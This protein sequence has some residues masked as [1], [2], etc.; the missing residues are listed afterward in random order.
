MSDWQLHCTTNVM[1]LTLQSSTFLFYVHF[2][3]LY[4]KHIFY[5]LSMC[6]KFNFILLSGWAH[7][8][9]SKNLTVFKHFCEKVGKGLIHDVTMQSNQ[10]YLHLVLF[11]TIY[12][13]QVAVLFIGPYFRRHVTLIVNTTSQYKSTPRRAVNSCYVIM[14]VSTLF[15]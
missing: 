5:H 9:Q 2:F 7:L 11:R 1:I 13:Y 8:F 15:F 6:H 12:Y 4:F 3:I 10:E 14:T